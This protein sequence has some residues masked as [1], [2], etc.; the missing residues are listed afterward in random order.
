MSASRP[1]APLANIS[2]AAN[3]P[4]HSLVQ[5]TKRPRAQANQQQQ[6][7]EPPQKR[8]MVDKETA[9]TG[10]GTPP[11][12]KI[13]PVSAEGRVFEKGSATTQPN[14]F[15]RKLVAARERGQPVRVTK[16]VDGP[17]AQTVENIRQWQKHYRKAFPSFSFYF[18]SVPED[19]RARFA[20]Q[21][22][23]LGAVGLKIP[24]LSLSSGVAF[25]R[26]S[27]GQ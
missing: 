4:H 13:P 19:V 12:K 20:R 5:S 14:A 7:N 25:C 11:S 1:R 10:L 17:S 24:S 21:I 15:Q 6:E 22:T 23:S 9:A 2:N 8:Q 27:A 16:S 18:D 3:S 26:P